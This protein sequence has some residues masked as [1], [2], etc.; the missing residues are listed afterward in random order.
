VLEQEVLEQEV[1]DQEVLDQEV[2]GLMVQIP[3]EG[4]SCH[5]PA[6]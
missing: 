6:G 4:K 2:L 3:G 5:M 1:L